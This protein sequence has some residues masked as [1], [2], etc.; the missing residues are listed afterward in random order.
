MAITLLLFPASG[1]LFDRAISSVEGNSADPVHAAIQID[2]NWLVEAVFPVVRAMPVASLP[3]D[4]QRYPLLLTDTQAVAVTEYLLARVGRER[5]SMR[6]IA[7]DAIGL[8]TH[9][10][11]PAPTQ[12]CDC[13]GLVAECLASVGI[14]PF[15]PKD[16]ADVTPQDLAVWA[17]SQKV[18]V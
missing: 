16:T 9:R 11:L 17:S 4:V 10:W 7:I 13:S 12:E 18:S 3:A 15:A 14:T 2:D 8:T 6:Q 5:Y 1:T